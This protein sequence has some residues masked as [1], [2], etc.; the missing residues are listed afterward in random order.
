MLQSV[1]QVPSSMKQRRLWQYSVRNSTNSLPF[2]APKVVTQ[3]CSSVQIH[4]FLTQPTWCVRMRALVW[5]WP[6]SPKQACVTARVHILQGVK[7]NLVKNNNVLNSQEEKCLTTPKYT[8][9]P[10]LYRPG[11]AVSAPVGWG[12]QN[13]WTVMK[14]ARLSAMRTNRLYPPTPPP[15]ITSSTHF[16]YRLSRPQCDSAAGKIKSIKNVI[17]PSR[18]RIRFITACSAVPKSNASPRTP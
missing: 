7:M 8:F 2:R 9:K 14:V 5:K 16:C 10:S 15:G 13:F 6:K 17:D 11:Q 12:P 3:I 1:C 18:N 4:S